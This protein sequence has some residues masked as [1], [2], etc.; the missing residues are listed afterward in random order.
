VLTTVSTDNMEFAQSLGADIVIAYKKQR[1]VD[2]VSQLDMVLDRIN[3]E[4]CERSWKLLKTGG[5]PVT[6][7]TDPSQEKAKAE[8]VRAIRYT[9]EADGAELAELVRGGKVK[10]HVEK[11]FPLAGA[12]DAPASAEEGHSR[13][14]L[15]LNV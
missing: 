4:A 11:T 13:G 9:V 8:S 2:E 7:L 10:P 6:T 1:F 12:V 15:V 5:T 14:K 3:G